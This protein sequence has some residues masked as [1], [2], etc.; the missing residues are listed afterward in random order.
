VPPTEVPSVAVPD[1]RSRSE[2]EAKDA[3]SKAGLQARK[4]DKCTGEEQGDAKAKKGRIMCQNP[5]AKAIVP[6]GTVVEYVI[7]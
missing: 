7:K 4:V 5:A 2:K 1:V 3:L 6:L